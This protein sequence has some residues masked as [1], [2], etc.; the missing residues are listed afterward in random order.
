MHELFLGQSIKKIGLVFSIIPRL[1][2]AMSITGMLYS[3]VMA[4]SQ[5]DG[6]EGKYFVV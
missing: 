1:K 6:T 2:Q 4:C 5:V 3:G